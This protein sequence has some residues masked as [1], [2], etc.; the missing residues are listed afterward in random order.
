MHHAVVTQ[1]KDME[2]SVGQHGPC[3]C[4]T[5]R[6]YSPSCNQHL[7]FTHLSAFCE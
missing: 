3:G 7:G 5:Q 2:G 6:V 1:V 4:G